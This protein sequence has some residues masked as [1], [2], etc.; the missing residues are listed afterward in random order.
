MKY[1]Y[2]IIH[3]EDNPSITGP[4]KVALDAANKRP[5]ASNS[6]LYKPGFDSDGLVSRFREM[7]ALIRAGNAD[8]IICI[9]DLM[10]GAQDRDAGLRDLAEVGGIVSADPFYSSVTHAY[11]FLTSVEEKVR[12]DPR[13]TTFDPRFPVYLWSKDAVPSKLGTQ[14][15]GFLENDVLSDDPRNRLKNVI[16]RWRP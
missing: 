8:R 5:G 4:I 11:A 14:L 1:E 10:H 7:G 2:A 6:F 13:A 12:F 3:K 16:N 15:V 9:L